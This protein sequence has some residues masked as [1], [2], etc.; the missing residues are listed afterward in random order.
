MALPGATIHDL[1]SIVNDFVFCSSNILLF[2]FGSFNLLD[3]AIS[4]TR[5]ALSFHAFL[6]F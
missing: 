2:D 6:C 5:V 4:C 1:P 3:P